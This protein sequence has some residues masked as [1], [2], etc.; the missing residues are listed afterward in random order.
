MSRQS[1]KFNPRVRTKRPIGLVDDDDQSPSSPHPKP[2]EMDSRWFL[3]NPLGARLHQKSGIGLTLDG[4]IALDPIEV[5]FCHWNRHI[6]VTNQWV[7]DMIKLDSDFIAKSVIFDVARSGGEIV[8][9]ITNFTKNDYSEGTFA[10]KWPRN[11]SHFSTTP[12]S[13]IRWFWSFDDV[14]WDSLNK[15]V[16]NVEES[17]CMAEVFV[18]DDEMD[19]TMYRISFDQLSGNQKT[20]EQLTK[21]EISYIENSLSNRIKSSS[22]VFLSKVNDWPLPSFGVE[23]LSGINL[24]NEE[25]DWVESHLFGNNMDESLFNKLANSGCTLRP[26]FKYGCKWRVYDDEV[27]KSHAPWLLQPL[28][29]APSSWEGICL[30]VRLAEGVHKKWVCAIPLNDDWKFINIKRWLPGRN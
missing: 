6:P 19:I 1:R 18:I 9:P 14:D 27:G 21:S 11:K 12:V 17:D 10:V 4:G 16:A 13:Q 3:P 23:H 5:L 26:G 28:S 20:W 8:I 25:I 29:D 2:Q 22:G 15:W 24:R 30:S 7:E